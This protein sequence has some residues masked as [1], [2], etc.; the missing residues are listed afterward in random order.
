MLWVVLNFMFCQPFSEK[1]STSDFTK[2]TTR[3]PP[4]GGAF[5]DR[6]GLAVGLQAVLQDKKTCKNGLTHCD[7]G[8]ET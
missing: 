7:K 4:C 5:M 3:A 2:G 6:H 1:E 8:Q